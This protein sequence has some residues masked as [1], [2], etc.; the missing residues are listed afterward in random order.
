MKTLKI[1]LITLATIIIVAGT[2]FFLLGFLKPKPAGIYVSTS[3]Q[4]S[5]YIDGSFMGKTPF[6]KTLAAGTINIKLVPDITDQ[7]LY[8]FETKLS[9]VPGIQTVVR[10]EFG[11]SEEDSSGDI[12]SFEKEGGSE[13]GLIVISTPD[14]AQVSLDGVPRG[15]APYKVSSISPAEHQITVK[16]SGYSDRVMTVNT[17]SGYRLTLFAKLAISAD[18]ISPGATPTPT[19][20]P[21][22]MVLILTTPT[23]YL[24]VRSE[25][26]T[27][28]EEIGQVKP[29]DKLPF[30]DSDPATGW[31]K[32]QFEAPQAGLP[33]GISGWVSNQYARQIDATGN[34]IPSVSPSPT[35]I[36]V[37]Y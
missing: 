18:G 23:G 13:A 29:G 32:I 16:A 25:P 26:G 8:P 6:Q 36:S 12:I 5:I 19:P 33:E 37:G 2:V 4:A 24:R 15:F 3:P 10:R 34:P 17:V 7:S 28:G 1:V 14:N 35:P 27:K 9:L 30:L 20:A 21:K 22:S 31:L 11:K